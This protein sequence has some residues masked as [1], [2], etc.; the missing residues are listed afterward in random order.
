MAIFK[1]T[2]NEIAKNEELKKFRERIAELERKGYTFGNFE[3][4]EK[5]HFKNTASGYAI[6]A[7]KRKT[8][9]SNCMMQCGDYFVEDGK[10]EIGE[11][12]YARTQFKNT[13]NAVGYITDVNR[14]KHGIRIAATCFTEYE[15][16]ML[17]ADNITY[18]I[19]EVEYDEETIFTPTQI[20]DGQSTDEQYPSAKAVY[21]LANARELLSRKTSSVTSSNK[22]STTYYPS[23]KALTG[24]A[25]ALTN[26]VTSI[27]EKSTDTQYPSAKAVYDL[28]TGSIPVVAGHFANYEKKDLRYSELGWH[29][30]I[31]QVTDNRIAVRFENE[32]FN[33]D[34]Q[35]RILQLYITSGGVKYLIQ[36]NNNAK[37]GFFSYKADVG[38]AKEAEK[39]AT[40]WCFGY[41]EGCVELYL[42]TDTIANIS[43]THELIITSAKLSDFSWNVLAE[44]NEVSFN[45]GG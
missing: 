2:V 23:V 38:G 26:K 40:E 45:T 8:R 33:S 25:E 14:E 7:G 3:N 6:T 1:G 31:K 44:L 41:D 5:I 36:I 37:K 15:A 34:V 16:V 43:Q 29:L 19:N 32:Y 13:L 21:T 24:Y 17:S 11:R 18:T 4:A 12:V 22:S 30:Y 20:I 42:D 9:T 27:S 35:T 39:G 10:I 28:V